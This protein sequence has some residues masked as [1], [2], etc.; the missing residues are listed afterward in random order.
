MLLTPK[1]LYPKKRE[2][3]L[4]LPIIGRRLIPASMT[5]KTILKDTDQIIQT[6]NRDIRMLMVLQMAVAVIQEQH[7]GC[8]GHMSCGHVIDAIANL[9][10]LTCHSLRQSWGD[11]DHD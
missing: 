4:S 9:F 11:T 3:I 7:G 6:L 10:Q 5:N 2:Y 1:E 8:A